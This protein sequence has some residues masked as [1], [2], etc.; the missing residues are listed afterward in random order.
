[1]NVTLRRTVPEGQRV[2]SQT[3]RTSRCCVCLVGLFT[4]GMRMLFGPCEGCVRRGRGVV[5]DG[6]PM[7][8]TQAIIDGHWLVLAQ[9]H[10]AINYTSYSSLSPF[11]VAGLRNEG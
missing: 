11:D 2:A 6:V 8:F 3:I 1:M 10:G 7:A 5:V 9:L 4:T